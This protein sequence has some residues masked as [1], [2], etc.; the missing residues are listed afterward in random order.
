MLTL[1][2]CVAVSSLIEFNP[3][4]LAAKITMVS[5]AAQTLF[6]VLGFKS[7]IKGL[8]FMAL[9]VEVWSTDIAENLYN[10]N[11]FLT[12]STDH[13]EW[14][15]YKTVHLPQAGANM[16]VKKDRQILPAQITERTD[17]ELTYNLGEYTAE[18]ILIRNIDEIQLSYPKRQ[19][20]LGQ[21]QMVLSDT[22]ANQSLY[23][24]APSL[25][26]SMVKTTGTADG[27]ALAPSA[28]GTRNAITLKD[29]QGA[30]AILDKQNVPQSGRVLIIPSDMY[31]AQL[32]SIPNII[33][34]YQNGTAV[35]PTGVVAKLFGFD[36]YV[37]ASVLVYDNSGTPV[38]KT[39]GD[40]GVPSS[41]AATDMLAA[42]A[43]HPMFVAKALGD[44]K[45]FYDENK[46]E[47]YGS[48]F[49]A[50]VMHGAS[51]IRT[52]QIGVVAIVQA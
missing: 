8:A 42:L 43:Y 7:N 16:A 11:E 50:L 40:N 32:L 17:T 1:F 24:W 33:Q 19:S 29:I 30:K 26:A 36:I 39:I 9:Q 35:L 3:L 21:Y 47:Y 31:N 23:S 28:T 20:V 34:Y 48:I 45:V 44:I 15:N 27:L 38:I 12:R 14:V 49:S 18:P 51:K 13:S 22:V 41:P 5:F 52:S 25:L 10:N 6:M 2:V 4:E 46:P 37:R